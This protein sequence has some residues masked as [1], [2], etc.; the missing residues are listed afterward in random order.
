ML[1]VLRKTFYINIEPS[2]CHQTC[3]LY[4]LQNN[5]NITIKNKKFQTEFAVKT[6]KYS[7]LD[8]VKMPFVFRYMKIARLNIEIFC[9][10]LN[11]L[12][13][14]KKNVFRF[15][16]SFTFQIRSIYAQKMLF[17]VIKM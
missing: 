9:Y 17:H 1:C 16:T 2:W 13:A 14:K 10:L 11:T 8:I 7:M 3:A 4:H 12:I 15:S 5:L 6:C